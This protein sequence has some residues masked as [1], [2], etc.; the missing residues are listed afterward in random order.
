MKIYT[1]KGDR[2]ETST[3]GGKRVLKCDFNIEAV[4]DIDELN[5]VLGM[6]NL[7]ETEKIQSD[8]LLIGAVVSGKVFSIKYLVFRVKEMEKEIDRMWG[9][10]PELKNFIIFGGT[11][12]TSLLYL[13]RAVC[14]RAERS[15]VALKREDFG[16][17][18]KYMNRL[19]D[20]LF[21][22]G[23]WVNFKNNVA[24]KVWKKS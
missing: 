24:E 11:E 16:T 20:Y 5:A 23:R 22:L 1:K 4:G 9:E 19:S 8:L 2:G 14:R 7:L 21:C 6:V 15:I 13:A 12:K 17:V 10:M 18:I 3:Y